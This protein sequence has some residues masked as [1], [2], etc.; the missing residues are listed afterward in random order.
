MPGEGRAMSELLTIEEIEARYPREWVLLTDVE[1]DP[2]PVIRRGRVVW[3]GLDTD[4]A[5]K[6]AQELPVPRRL[7]VLFMGEI[8]A[9]EEPILIL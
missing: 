9:D 4:E 6:L 1:S 2:G 8:Y 7:A 3:H 5:W